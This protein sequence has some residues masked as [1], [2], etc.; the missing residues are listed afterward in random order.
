[1]SETIRVSAVF[2]VKR[3][4]LYNAWLDSKTQTAFTGAKAR[5]NPKVGGKFSAWDGYI[6]G[7][8]LLLKR[9]QKIVQ[10][11]RTTDFPEGSPDSVLVVLFED[12]PTGT[13]IVLE[14]SDIPEGQAKSY[15][16]G[17]K[18]FYF[19]PMKQYYRSIKKG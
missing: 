9:G 4:T 19:S 8:T 6:T 3:A 12:T 18:D 14:H 15:R 13:R 17:W 16:A 10:S 1:M 7:K 2:P 11:W 5:V